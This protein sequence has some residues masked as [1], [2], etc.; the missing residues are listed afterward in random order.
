M[1]YT[2]S[3][4]APFSFR[5]FPS[6]PPPCLFLSLLHPLPPSLPPSLGSGSVANSG[7]GRSRPEVQVRLESGPSA[8]AHSPLSEHNGFLQCRLHALSTDLLMSTLQNLG[9][10]VEDSSESQVLPMEISLRDVHVNLKVWTHT[11]THT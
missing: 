10:F 6:S 5:L 4:S 8:A 7:P 9:H 2:L 3:V 11:H 1:L